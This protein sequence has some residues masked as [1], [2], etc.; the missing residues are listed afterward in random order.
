M[1]YHI[2]EARY[3]L[4][5]VSSGN[6]VC[7]DGFVH[8]RRN[9][10]SFVLILVVRGTLPITQGEN[11]Y[12]VGE[13]QALLLFPH[14]LHYGHVPSRG[15]LSYYWV[16]FY[17]TDPAAKTLSRDSLAPLLS[18]QNEIN[19]QNHFISPGHYIIPEYSQL[20]ELR[21]SHLLFVQLLDIAKRDNYTQTWRCHYALSLLLLEVSTESYQT[22][23]LLPD[24]LP[25]VVFNV[26]EWI[27]ANYDK[28]LTVA[29]IAEYFNYHPTYLTSL[30]KN[31]TQYSILS[32]L[33]RTRINASKN[34]L[35][36][37]DLHVHQVGELCGI[38]DGKYFMKLFKRYEGITPTQYRRA[39][40][41]KR[42]NKA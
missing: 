8:P 17:V 38:T 16:H 1:L 35:T 3:P 7:E 36:N 37:R 5:Y 30:F 25:V 34:L 27:R 12:M 28:P 14:T 24:N 2:S 33:N 32:Y 11:C 20:S 26:M 41:Q 42:I 4:Q 15:E 18:L 40:Y 19:E 31:S 29:S 9:I 22:G 10:D 21:R 13:N 23:H 39:F 6:L